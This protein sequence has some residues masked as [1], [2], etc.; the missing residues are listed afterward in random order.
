MKPRLR[1]TTSCFGSG[2]TAKR[3]G[4]SLAGLGGALLGRSHRSSAAKA[5]LG[6]LL[7]RSRALLGLPEDYRIGLVAGSDTGAFEM[8][9]WSLL[10]ARGTDLLAWESFGEGWLG[11]ARE[12]LRLEDLRIFRADYG[13]LPDLDVVAADRDVVFTW[14]GTTSGCRGASSMS[15]PIPGRRSSAAR[16]STACWCWARARSS[17]SRATGRR[18]RCRSC[19][20]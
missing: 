20:A 2:P 7:E 6:E 14:N 12:Q 4:W 5:R 11:D 3:P 9:M 18:G 16:R 1:P 15:R 13:Q 17:G 19:S 10:G 8:A